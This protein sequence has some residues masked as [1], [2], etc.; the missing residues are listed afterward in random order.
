MKNVSAVDTMMIR[1]DN[2]YFMLTNICS[3]GLGDY[4]SELHIFYSAKIDSDEWTPIES[5]NPVI[6]DSL[7][8]RNG[9]MFYSNGELYRV[10][11]IHGKCHYG[12]SFGVNRI[13]VLNEREYSEE[14]VLLMRSTK[15]DCILLITSMRML[16]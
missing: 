8:A 2:L 16:R 13:S 15:K 3:A 1:R 14:R 5:G 12:K 9:G 10:N 11:Q 7:S 6:F 4:G